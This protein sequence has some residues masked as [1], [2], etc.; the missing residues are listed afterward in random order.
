MTN[1]VMDR[2]PIGANAS[3]GPFLRRQQGRTGEKEA[4]TN[5][6]IA[7][8]A[9]GI[10]GKIRAQATHDQLG[11]CRRDREWPTGESRGNPSDARRKKAM[12]NLVIA[13][14]TGD[15]PPVKAGESRQMRGG[16]S[17]DQLGHG[18]RREPFRLRRDGAGSSGQGSAS[19][20]DSRQ[21]QQKRPG[22][23]IGC[24]HA[25][26]CL[27]GEETLRGPLNASQSLPALA[28]SSGWSTDGKHRGTSAHR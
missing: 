7:A 18:G 27:R 15:G 1:L 24:S 11:H 10:Y 25:C 13:E 3:A 12:T 14:G 9:A 22:G 19:D 23:Q 6:V 20:A 8:M 4:M 26:V 16:K 2:G 28:A 17:H 5:L 21:R